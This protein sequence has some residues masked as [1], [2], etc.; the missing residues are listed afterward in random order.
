MQKKILIV[1]SDASR[2]TQFY[3][4]LGRAAVSSVRTIA[5]P[6]PSHG[7]KGRTGH[8]PYYS[9]S[10]KRKFPQRSSKSSLY[11]QSGESLMLGQCSTVKDVSN[12]KSQRRISSDFSDMTA[13]TRRDKASNTCKKH[14]P[15]DGNYFGR[16]IPVDVDV[17]NI[18]ILC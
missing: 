6:Q 3:S 12:T 2:N 1:A 4:S 16:C 15:L 17:T 5:E 10:L 8:W 14:A 13:R 7:S 11:E 18:Q 9:Y